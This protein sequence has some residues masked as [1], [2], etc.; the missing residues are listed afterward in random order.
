MN[1]RELIH[2]LVVRKLQSA[3][4][5][6]NLCWAARALCFCIAGTA[7]APRQQTPVANPKS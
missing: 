7:A 2:R 4:R 3:G 1:R 6:K 5:G